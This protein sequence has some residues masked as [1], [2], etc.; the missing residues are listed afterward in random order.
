M[1]YIYQDLTPNGATLDFLLYS[2]Y[3]DHFTTWSSSVDDLMTTYKTTKRLG[4]DSEYEGPKSAKAYIEFVEN[5][6][7]GSSM[8]L[9]AKVRSLDS[10]QDSHPELFI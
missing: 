1:F 3:D 4:M 5:R 9:L 2:S 10:L 6:Y 8:Q 7:E